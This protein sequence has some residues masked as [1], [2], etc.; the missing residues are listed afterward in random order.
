VTLSE[1]KEATMLLVYTGS[2]W[3]LL[4]RGIAAIAFGILAFVW[5]QIT[6][7]VLVFL[8]GA[9]ALVDGMFAI[10]AG[11]KTYGESKRWWVLL[12]EGLLSVA[13]GVVAF[14]MPGITAL[15][16]L[17]L[18]AS[19]AIV[20]GVFEIVAAIQLRKEIKG[21]WL[22]ALAG[23]ASILFGVLLFINPGAG[24]LTV[25]W[26]IGAYA[27]VFGALLIALGLRLRGLV[28]S[29]DRMSP[30]AV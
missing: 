10:A 5:P 12:L 15:I 2:W 4:L 27:I 19:W 23:V 6:L 8:W 30:R 29:A 21:E 24:A 13:A 1:R 14:A 17:I 11:V 7:T 16:L 25:V 9:Y 3:A 20:T 22:L 28:R 26:L 18:I